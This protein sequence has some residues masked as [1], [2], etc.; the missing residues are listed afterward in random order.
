MQMYQEIASNKSSQ[1]TLHCF[2]IESVR[3]DAVN[4]T[5]ISDQDFV[6]MLSTAGAYTVRKFMVLVGSCLN[7]GLQ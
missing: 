6:A 2:F 7:H 5:A 3:F 1:N 4:A